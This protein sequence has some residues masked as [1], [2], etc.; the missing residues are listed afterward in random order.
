MAQ[1][2]P[3]PWV[4]GSSCSSLIESHLAVESVQISWSVILF[5]ARL[6][7]SLK[8]DSYLISLP[9]LHAALQQSS[10]RKTSQAPIQTSICLKIVSQTPIPL[11]YNVFN[12]AFIGVKSNGSFFNDQKNISQDLKNSLKHGNKKWKCICDY[13]RIP[14]SG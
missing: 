6:I 14:C 2:S 7:W 8:G 1:I 10:V 3:V 9:S 13:Y 11:P 4:M 12:F 5:L